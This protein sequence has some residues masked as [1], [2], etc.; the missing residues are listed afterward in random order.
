MGRQTFNLNNKKVYGV[1]ADGVYFKHMKTMPNPFDNC[2]LN[3]NVE[4]LLIVDGTADWNLPIPIEMHTIIEESLCLI[5]PYH[6]KL[7]NVIVV[8]DVVQICCTDDEQNINIGVVKLINNRLWVDYGK[9][10]DANSVCFLKR[11]GN[12]VA[13]PTLIKDLNKSKQ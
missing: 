6:D 13:N 5:T 9:L 8:N 10:I 2:E 12:I 11:L 4:H 3:N 7:N 1:W